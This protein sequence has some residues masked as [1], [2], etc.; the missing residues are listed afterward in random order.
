MLFNKKQDEDLAS[1]RNPV[2][3]TPDRAPSTSKKPSSAGTH[4]VIDPWL[5]ITG[6][7]GGDGELQVDG[8]VNGNIR[9]ARLVVG[10]AGAINGSVTA[11]E[12][13]VR[14]EVKGVIR[15]NRVMLL[16][17]ARVESE[18]FHKTLTIEQG[19]C[20]QGQVRFRED[21]MNAE[22]QND[23]IAKLQETAATMQ[24]SGCDLA[25]QAVADSASVTNGE[26][27]IQLAAK[28]D[29]APNQA[30]GSEMERLRARLR[31]TG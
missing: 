27:S 21:P 15:A 2:N 1:N 22:M 11:D 24:S 31:M 8:K 23:Q 3:S 20:F 26:A 4:S 5:L 18:I 19:A 17:S 14:G 6:D 9:C 28:V 10:K 13:I 7:L 12:V 30:F 16:D 25:N 29:Q